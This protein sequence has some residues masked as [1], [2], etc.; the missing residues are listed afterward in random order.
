MLLEV[1][2]DD[3]NQDSLEAHL[4]AIELMPQVC[5][6][7]DM[8]TE[9]GEK[10]IDR[11]C[12]LL[13]AARNHYSYYLTSSDTLGRLVSYPELATRPEDCAMA[14]MYLGNVLGFR[15]DKNGADAALE[16]AEKRFREMGNDM[17]LAH[18]LLTKAEVMRCMGDE[19][20]AKIILDQAEQ[21]CQQLNDDLGLANVF[22]TRGDLLLCQMD[23]DGA[24]SAYKDAE[25]K[26]QKMKDT[27]GMA[28][29]IQSRGLLLGNQGE[30]NKALKLLD[31]AY[32]LYQKFHNIS[33]QAS[34]LEVQYLFL[35]ESG[36]AGEAERL[37]PLLEDLLPNLPLP[38]QEGVRDTLAYVPPK[39]ED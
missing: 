1:A 12:W 2:N 3:S 29:L 23:F 38:Q 19:S 7:L 4:L 28:N 30:I 5:H 36:Q 25:E 35:M 27:I 32:I 20:E 39:P 26:S 13:E 18:T 22:R 37:R 10:E 11:L 6:V 16:Q 21:L 14:Y 34:C 9:Q 24:E 31:E 17:G 8:L 33:G 15:G